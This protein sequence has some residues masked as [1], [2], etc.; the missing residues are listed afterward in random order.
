MVFPF[1]ESHTNEP[2]ALGWINEQLMRKLNDRLKRDGREN[3]AEHALQNGE[4]K[5]TG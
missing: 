5:S 2:N 3:T 4:V 1:S